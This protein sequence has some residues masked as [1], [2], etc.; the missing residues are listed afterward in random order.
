MET[1]CSEFINKLVG[2]SVGLQETYNE[3]VNYWSPEEPPIT[4]AFGDLGCRIADD[5]EQFNEDVASRIFSLIETA[6]THGDDALVTAVATG[7]I[8]AVVGRAG[9][10]GRGL[11]RILRAFGE[12][13]RIHA[14]AWLTF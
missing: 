11:P 5:F 13:S 10:Q 2:L 8:E 7:L 4:I 3:T 1:S 14:E 12:L 6:M 9:A